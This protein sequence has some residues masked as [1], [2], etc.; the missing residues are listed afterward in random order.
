[1]PLMKLSSFLMIKD[2]Y[3]RAAQWIE[4]NLSQVNALELAAAAHAVGFEKVRAAAV[5]VVATHFCQYKPT[6]LA[7]LPTDLLTNVLHDDTLVWQAAHTSHVVAQVVSAETLDCSMVERL[8]GRPK[9]QRSSRGGKKTAPTAGI[10]VELI[11]VAAEDVLV[12]L[13]QAVKHKIEPL[14]KHCQEVLVANFSVAVKTTQ[15]ASALQCL[16]LELLCSVLQRTELKVDDEDDVFHLASSWLHAAGTLG[17]DQTAKLWK[18]V[19]F[20]WLSPEVLRRASQVPSIPREVLMDG[21]ISRATIERDGPGAKGVAPPRTS[22][23]AA[24][25]KKVA[26]R[27]DAIAAVAVALKEEEIADLETEKEA[28]E[29]DLEGERRYGQLRNQ[30]LQQTQTRV[31]QLQQQMV[32][33]K[34]W[35]TTGYGYSTQ[36][37]HGGPPLFG[38][39]VNPQYRLH[40]A[41]QRAYHTQ[42][43]S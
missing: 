42:W 14:R 1:V 4:D 20:A 34:D 27:E 28:L 12:M 26:D 6:A 30:Q 41:Y 36:G 16:P 40:Q 23:R 13:S 25:K 5:A 9:K 18:C 37:G 31:Q 38:P 10:E 15:A 17:D 33:V 24:F 8:V 35:Q 3:S 19:R 7:S 29:A 39:V 2:L 21:A 22:V 32:R 43:M 11:E